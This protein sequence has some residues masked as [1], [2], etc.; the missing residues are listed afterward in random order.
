MKGIFNIGEVRETEN[1]KKKHV[2][3]MTPQEVQYLE[4]RLKQIDARRVYISNHVREKDVSFNLEEIQKVLNREDVKNLI[5]EYN[6]TIMTGDWLDFRVL[7]RTDE[8]KNVTFFG[9]KRIPFEAP[10]NMC[11]VISLKTLKV[12][13]VYWNKAN[14]GHRGMDWTR[15]DKNLLIVREA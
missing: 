15:Y 10:A 8:V 7:L 13:T 12:I 6:E 3:Q 11:F 2:E 14:D 5:V 9:T 4:M 1:Q